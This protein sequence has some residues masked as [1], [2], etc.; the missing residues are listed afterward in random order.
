M[1]ILDS[2]KLARELGHKSNKA[3]LELY[4]HL[5][6]VRATNVWR[7]KVYYKGAER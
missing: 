5:D 6:R 2:I 4:Y 3:Q 7:E 1:N